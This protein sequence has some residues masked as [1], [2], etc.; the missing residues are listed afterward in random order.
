[1]D[2]PLAISATEIYKNNADC[3]DEEA[4]RAEAQLNEFLNE[5]SKTQGTQNVQARRNKII[6]II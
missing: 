2:S 4:R 1:M 6:W 3:Y 5:F